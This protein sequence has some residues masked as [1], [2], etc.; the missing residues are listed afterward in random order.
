MVEP[1]N[2]PTLIILDL[3]SLRKLDLLK[4]ANWQFVQDLDSV[5]HKYDF[6]D[7]VDGIKGFCKNLKED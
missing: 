3:E 4:T 1:L 6:E 5:E 7:L 2:Q